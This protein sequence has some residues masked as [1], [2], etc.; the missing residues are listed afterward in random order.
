MI[1]TNW[2]TIS[3]SLCIYIDISYNELFCKD[4]VLQVLKLF[5]GL[6]GQILICNC[7]KILPCQIYSF[8]VN[9]PFKVVV[10][11]PQSL[12]TLSTIKPITFHDPPTVVASGGGDVL[13]WE[14]PLQECNLP[15]KQRS[16]KVRSS[17]IPG[18]LTEHIN[19]RSPS[20]SWQRW[21]FSRVLPC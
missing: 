9:S 17:K 6:S 15:L 5:E 18:K 2:T 8:I 12:K 14:A 13:G 21:Q 16:I 19:H 20:S 11:V 7:G 10:V 3:N 1:F 4:S